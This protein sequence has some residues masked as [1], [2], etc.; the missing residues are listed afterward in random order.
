MISLVDETYFNRAW[1]AVEVVVM[2][3]LLSYGHHKHLEHHVAENRLV[4][5]RSLNRVRDV[6]TND[7]KYGVTQPEDRASIRFLARQSE[8]LAKVDTT[9]CEA[10]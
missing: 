6:A 5:S 7:A 2:Q 10:K 4:P 8:L 9:T 3:S 1:C